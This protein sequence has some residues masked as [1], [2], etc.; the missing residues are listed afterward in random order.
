MGD[1]LG[2]DTIDGLHAEMDG[3]LASTG[4]A[5]D[6]VPD[7][8]PAP[9]S[10]TGG[11]LELFTYPLLVDEGRLSEGATEL[12]AALEQEAFVEIHPETAAGLSVA[13]GLP[14]ELAT[15]AGAEVLPVKV[16][17][18]IAPGTVF[19]PFNQPGFAANRVLMGAFTAQASLT[20][21]GDDDAA[22]PDG[23]SPEAGAVPDDGAA[24]GTA[25]PRPAEGVPA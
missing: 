9:A 10:A 7:V 16:S 19:V 6:V 24:S 21:M 14:A 4:G 23:E 5:M 25:P 2:F 3:L 18:G 12:K 15:D 11:S 20:L 13:D 17:D 8:S 22:P 1:D